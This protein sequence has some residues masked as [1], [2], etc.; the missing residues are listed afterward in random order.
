MVYAYWSTGIGLELIGTFSDKEE[1]MKFAD[2]LWDSHQI[3]IR[4][5]E[6]KL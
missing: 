1:A 4:L 3:L 5:S 2:G 6:E